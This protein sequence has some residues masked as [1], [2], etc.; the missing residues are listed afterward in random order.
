LAVTAEKKATEQK[1]IAEGAKKEAV[2]S[3]VKEKESADK[4]KQAK[5]EAEA[6]AAAATK[7]EAQAKTDR[8]NALAA[9]DAALKARKAEEYQGYIA[10]IGLANAKIDD[11]AFDTAERLLDECP[12]Q[13]RNWEWGRLQYLTKQSVQSFAPPKKDNAPVARPVMFQPAGEATERANR[14]GCVLERR[15]AIHRRKLG[16]SGPHLGRQE[17][18]AVAHDP[19]WRSLR[20][21]RRV[22]SE[23]QVRRARR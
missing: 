20:S 9:E 6:N 5:Q 4:A 2:A 15:R 16:R 18:P 1:D 21:R 3:A 7:A 12:V 22:F 19:L 13:L 11:N 8:D 23:R 10:R 14:I 17:R